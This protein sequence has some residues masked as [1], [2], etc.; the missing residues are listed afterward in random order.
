[1]GEEAM[2]AVVDVV[3]KKVSFWRYFEADARRQG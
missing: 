1:M 2:E 3:K